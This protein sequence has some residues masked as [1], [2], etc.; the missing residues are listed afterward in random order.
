MARRGS[1]NAE[2]L[3]EKFYKYQRIIL[4]PGILG[5]APC[6]RSRVAA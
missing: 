1:I 3:D 5:N 6:R 4:G 2:A